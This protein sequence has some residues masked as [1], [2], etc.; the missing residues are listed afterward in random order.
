[1]DTARRPAAALLLAGLAA[2]GE[3]A[4]SRSDRAVGALL[5][6][7]LCLA[8]GLALAW[9]HLC[10]LSDGRYHP[11]PAGRRAL[12]VLRS[13]WR[14]LLGR[15]STV[16]PSGEGNEA[17]EAEELMPWGAERQQREEEEEDG[18]E[19]APQEEEDEGEEEEED[20]EEEEQRPAEQ[21]HALPGDA[22]SLAG[23]AAWGDARPSDSTAL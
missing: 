2:A 8:V 20:E 19:E 12:A 10:R 14:R 1:M 5:G 6:L 3:P 11:R 22:H 4:V 7:L 15:E 13:R 16:E 21:P 9:R 17:P 18:E 23:T